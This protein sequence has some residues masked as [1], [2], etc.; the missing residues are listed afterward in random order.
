[1][2]EF[3]ILINELYGVDLLGIMKESRIL[4]ADIERLEADNER[5][6]A[7]T[8]RLKADNERLKAAYTERLED[9]VES[10][11]GL[12]KLLTELAA[13]DKQKKE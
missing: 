10:L 7:D 5:L 13:A 1:M 4:K 6:K 2:D 12:F 8:E 3:I 9:H 11:E